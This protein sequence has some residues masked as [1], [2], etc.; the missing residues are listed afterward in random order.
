MTKHAIYTTI[1]SATASA[2]SNSDT[3]IIKNNYSGNIQVTVFYKNG[4]H[5][6]VVP[7]KQTT[8]IISPEGYPIN[9]VSIQSNAG[10]QIFEGSTLPFL[11]TNTLIFNVDNNFQISVSNPFLNFL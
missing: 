7:S 4:D 5:Y 8:T 11:R 2:Y 9:S 10:G 6:K 3:V 1:A